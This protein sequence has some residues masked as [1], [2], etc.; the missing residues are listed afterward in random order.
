V[1]NVAL[2]LLQ[3]A[4]PYTVVFNR[5]HP[6]SSVTTATLWTAANGNNTMDVGTAS[7]DEQ[8]QAASAL[9]QDKDPAQIPVQLNKAG[10]EVFVKVCACATAC[11]WLGLTVLYFYH[12]GEGRS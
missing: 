9:R 4:N 6:Y 7:S 8:Q 3:K 2:T 5:G 10:E 12:P 1:S 11:C